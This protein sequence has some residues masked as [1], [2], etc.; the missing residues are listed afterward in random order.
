MGG[1]KLELVCA[2]DSG[3][4]VSKIPHEMRNTVSGTM[5][6]VG[7][8]VATT[9]RAILPSSARESVA[10]SAN[11]RSEPTGSPRA[12]RVTLTLS[13]FRSLER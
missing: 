12:M 5:N 10:S 13:G 4:R 2:G 9:Q 1:L 8:F 6:S 3:L 11:S 7:H